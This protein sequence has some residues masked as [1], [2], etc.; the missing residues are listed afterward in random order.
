MFKAPRLPALLA[1]SLLAAPVSAQSTAPATPPAAPAAPAT[2][3]PSGVRVNVP[4][5]AASA[6]GIEVSRVAKGRL[7]NCPT[8]LKL[9]PNALCFYSLGAAPS[10]RPLIKDQLG[11]RAGEWKMAGKA[12]SLAVTS[13]QTLALVLLAQISPTETVVVVDIPAQ[14]ASAKPSVPAGVVKNEPYLLGS[15]LKGLVT[16][17]ALS[18]TQF[19][20]ERSGQPALTV[21]AGQTAAQLGSGPV[22]LPLAPASDGQNLVLPFSLLTTLGCTFKPNSGVYTVA[23]GESSVGVKP[24]VF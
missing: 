2:P 10:L 19:K 4:S 14:T 18:A 9:S 1:I 7:V 3:A 23:C 13:G 22:T 16:V 11:K 5:N 21:T 8:A 17:T 12:S 24:I 6:L 20:L 15:D